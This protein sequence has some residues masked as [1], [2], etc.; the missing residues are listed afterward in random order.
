MSRDQLEEANTH[1][2]LWNAAQTQ[3]MKHGKMH[4]FLRMYWA[5]KAGSCSFFPLMLHLITL[6]LGLRCM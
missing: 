4:G 1:D 5:K 3:M 2:D 6:A